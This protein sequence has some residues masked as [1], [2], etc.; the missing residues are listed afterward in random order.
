MDATPGAG[1]ARA[2]S[3]VVHG[4]A[5]AKGLAAAVGAT[6]GLQTPILDG[7]RA[8]RSIAD[9]QVSR[10][11]SIMEDTVERAVCQTKDFTILSLLWGSMISVVISCYR[12][13][14]NQCPELGSFHV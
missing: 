10:P 3:G 14:T 7:R 6:P 12:E 9:T 11:H 13:T 8:S 2:A 4:G 1:S 5:A